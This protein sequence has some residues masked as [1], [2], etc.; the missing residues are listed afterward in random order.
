MWQQVVYPP[1]RSMNEGHTDLSSENRNSP[2]SSSPPFLFGRSLRK[3]QRNKLYLSQ[4]G[5]PHLDG[6]DLMMINVY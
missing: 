6:Y 1:L 4:K 3:I 5:F 2:L